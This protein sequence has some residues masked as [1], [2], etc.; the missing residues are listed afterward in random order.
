MDQIA[1]YVLTIPI[2]KNTIFTIFFIL[3]NLRLCYVFQAPPLFG[4]FF[5]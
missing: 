5:N 1:S 2:E 4:I 3:I